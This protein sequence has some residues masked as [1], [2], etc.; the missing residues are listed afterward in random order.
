ML[1]LQ[2]DAHVDSFLWLCVKCMC[3]QEEAETGKF[4][5]PKGHM[6]KKQ[7]HKWQGRINYLSKEEEGQTRVN[8]RKWMTVSIKLKQILNY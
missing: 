7:E 2:H 3:V 1:R 4:L 8:G 6:A 5:N